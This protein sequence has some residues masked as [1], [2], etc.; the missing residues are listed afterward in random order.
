MKRQKV[1]A[2]LTCV[3]MILVV[4][5]CT[6]FLV[7]EADHVCANG[8]CPICTCIRQAEETIRQIGSGT[9]RTVSFVL[10]VMLSAVLLMYVC[11]L[12]SGASLVSR[13]VR[14]ND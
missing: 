13:K 8:D 4:L 11:Q 6:F 14:L 12:I 5:F 3:T 9:A 10:T 7:G 1:L 2:L